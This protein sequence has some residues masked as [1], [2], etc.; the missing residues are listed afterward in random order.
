MLKERMEKRE[1][2]LG[3]RQR[4]G[5]IPTAPIVASADHPSEPAQHDRKEGYAY[6]ISPSPSSSS[7]SA[8][9]SEELGASD[10]GKLL[11]CVCH[12]A[13]LTTYNSSKV[14]CL[15]LDMT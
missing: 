2:L 12:N 4:A 3:E 15:R 9:A 14:P 1:W 8:S 11:Y 7:T 6:V 13:T 10:S 5:S